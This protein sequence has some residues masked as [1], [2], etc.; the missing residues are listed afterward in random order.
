MS[1][2][3]TDVMKKDARYNNPNVKTV[4][5]DLNLLEPGTRAAVIQMQELAK[6]AGHELKVAET[7]RSQA[8]QHYLYEQGFTQ[9]S[10]VG[11]HGYC[12]A[13][14][15]NLFVNGKYD[16]NGT[17]YEF[18]HAM[19]VRCLMVSGQG[20]GT[21]K[22]HHSFTDWDHVQR[23]PLFRQDE[24]FAGTWYPPATGYDPWKDMLNNKIANIG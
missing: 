3:Y 24:I 12:V 18:M 22:A 2:F 5:C 9:L 11:M 15:L 19:A 23:V 4:V 17:H 14:D 6:A 7:Y 21:A 20:W 8:R 1:N 13:A 10:H 16:P